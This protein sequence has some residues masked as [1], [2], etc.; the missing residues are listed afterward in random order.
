MA[1]GAATSRDKPSQPRTHLLMGRLGGSEAR[2]LLE[3]VAWLVVDW[4]LRRG[5]ESIGQS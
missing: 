5:L 1:T 2:R 3:E 4:S